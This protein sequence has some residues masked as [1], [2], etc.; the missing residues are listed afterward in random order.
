MARDPNFVPVNLDTA[1][2][3]I[4]SLPEFRTFPP[5]AYLVVLEDGIEQKEVNEHPS[6]EVKM[7]LLEIVE[8]DEKN[9]DARTAEEPP[10]VDD[11]CTLLF[12]L[13]NEIGAG[14]LKK[15][16][17]PLAKEL[18][19]TQVREV[20]ENSRGLKLLVILGRSYDKEKDRFYQRFVR[21]SLA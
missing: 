5:G 17:Q 2:D 7:K 19:Y 6:L 8:L 4:A 13:D 15:F 16:M 10:K 14:M 12:N 18:G 9:L 11:S 21:G 1:L 3:D 20:V